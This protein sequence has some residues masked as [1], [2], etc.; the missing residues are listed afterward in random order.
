MDRK[1]KNHYWSRVIDRAKIYEKKCELR[2]SYM[3]M[4]NYATVTSA[5]LSL[6][7]NDFMGEVW[8]DKFGQPLTAG[9]IMA[10]RRRKNWGN[11]TPNIRMGGVGL[12]ADGESTGWRSRTPTSRGGMGMSSPLATP[13]SG[14]FRGNFSPKRLSSRRGEDNS[15]MAS[16]SLRRKAF[17]APPLSPPPPLILGGEGRS[18]FTE[19]STTDA[20][21]SLVTAEG[22]MAK[23]DDSDPAVSDDEFIPKNTYRQHSDLNAVATAE[24]VSSLRQRTPMSMNELIRTGNL[25]TL[26]MA[27]AGDLR[28]TNTGRGIRETLQE[29]T[30]FSDII[31]SLQDELLGPGR[32]KHLV[33]G[34]HDASNDEYIGNARLRY[35]VSFGMGEDEKAPTELN[36]IQK[37]RRRVIVG[38]DV[39]YQLEPRQKKEM[40]ALIEDTKTTSLIEEKLARK[41]QW[42]E[43]KMMRRIQADWTWNLKA[44]KYFRILAEKFKARLEVKEEEKKKNTAAKKIQEAWEIYFA[45]I[46]TEK[47]RRIQVTL[48]KFSFRLLARLSRVRLRL[49]KRKV[50]K[51]YSDFSRQRFS[52]VMVKFRFNCI[53]VRRSEERR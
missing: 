18:I 43:D 33:T 29:E 45:P 21:N 12:R 8:T 39:D 51:F 42:E 27:G 36:E 38:Q 32:R 19:N 46:R 49:A 11:F 41:K 50:L 25:S 2:K 47:K 5:F 52:F 1:E 3:D 6:E 40:R 28:P 23:D 31:A 24:A 10:A 26:E 14:Y 16:Q 15:S 4:K 34:R 7:D 22:M 44:S 30:K 37:G 35:D 53:K 13:K 17:K 9:D 20:S 48:M